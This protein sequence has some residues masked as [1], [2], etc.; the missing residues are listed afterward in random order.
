MS[1]PSSPAAVQSDMNN[2]NDSAGKPC[3][4]EPFAREDRR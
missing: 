3:V 4:L 1:T 2:D